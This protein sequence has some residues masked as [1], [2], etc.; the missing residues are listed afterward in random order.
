MI[1]SNRAY[2][3]ENLILNCNENNFFLTNIENRQDKTTQNQFDNLNNTNFT[4]LRVINNIFDNEENK[5]SS[6]NSKN[7]SLSNIYIK[8]VCNNSLIKTSATP[9]NA[10]DYN[11]TNN[12]NNDF[13]N[14]QPVKKRFRFNSFEDIYPY[15]EKDPLIPDKIRSLDENEIINNFCK[16]FQND[17]FVG[18]EQDS[19]I[20]YSNTATE[21]FSK[22]DEYLKRKRIK[23][24]FD[25]RS[26]FCN[27]MVFIKSIFDFIVSIYKYLLKITQFRKKIR[28]TNTTL[29]IRK[30]RICF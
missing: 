4:N 12:Y 2:N 24:D 3:D 13:K 21:S 28:K 7:Q 1:N 10:N 23:P 14:E 15:F 8:N 11:N 20:F 22:C 9:Y 25:N 29:I 17:E 5:K 26:I 6:L 30:M 18:D 27:S 16:N 19:I